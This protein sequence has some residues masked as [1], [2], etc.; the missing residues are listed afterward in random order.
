MYT[1]LK[2][3]QVREQLIQKNLRVFT[4]KDFQRVFQAPPTSTKYYLEKFADEGLFLRIKRGVYALKTDQPAE[5][6]LANA[7]YKPSYISF[8]Y[9]LAYWNILPEMPYQITSATTK[10]TR[11]FE[12]GEGVTYTYFTIKKEAYTGYSLQKK[13]NKSFLIAD[14]EKALADYLY[15][16]S[17]GHRSLNSRFDISGVNKEKLLDYAKLY[18]RA[19]IFTLIKEL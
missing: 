13:D 12:V 19:K 16:V 11:T 3:L 15:Y 5:E 1:L 4:G 7:L 18:N 10:P 9:A 14:P 17:I 8:E 2:P 6:E